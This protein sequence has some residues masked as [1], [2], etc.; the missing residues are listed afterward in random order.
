MI[1]DA[2]FRVTKQGEWSAITSDKFDT[3]IDMIA[4]EGSTTEV[5]ITI[6]TT[7]DGT[8]TEDT[9]TDTT[10]SD[11][12]SSSSKPSEQPEL[13]SINYYFVLASILLLP[14][15]RKKYHRK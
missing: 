14:I 6:D 4:Y 9:T 3:V 11:I 8:T 1:S 5:T 7:T 13:V 10:T 15:L 2:V 12:L